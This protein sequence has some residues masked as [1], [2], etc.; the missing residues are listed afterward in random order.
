[1]PLRTDWQ[2]VFV[3]ANGQP[4]PSANTVIYTTDDL[5]VWARLLGEYLAEGRIVALVG[6]NAQAVLDRYNTI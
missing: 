6:E 3:C 4:H 1:M 5:D 2:R